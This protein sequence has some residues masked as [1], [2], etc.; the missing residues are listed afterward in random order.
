[1]KLGNQ[2][3][4]LLGIGEY[5]TV[6]ELD[7]IVPWLENPNDHLKKTALIA[8]GMLAR[9]EAEEIYWSFLQ[10]PEPI[11]YVQAY[12][13]IVKYHV[14]YGSQ[15]LYELYLERRGTPAADYLLQLLTREPS[16]KRLSYLL[17]VCDDPCLSERM[18]GHV[19]YGICHRS[20]YGCVTGQEA[21]T[22]KNLLEEKRS[23]LPPKT[24]ENILWDLKFV[25]R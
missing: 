23:C 15:R 10:K 16:W 11:L 1:M 22:I 14:S 21:D 6:R 9:D 13:L 19:F 2:K 20:M 24:E 25:T 3:I 5:G 12:R 17:R 8:Y 18:R 4:A 7:L